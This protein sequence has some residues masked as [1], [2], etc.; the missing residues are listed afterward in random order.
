[1]Q[2]RISRDIRTS[3]NQDGAVVLNVRANR[4]LNLNLAGAAIL[5]ML[6]CGIVSTEVLAK[7]LVD[8]HG[9]DATTA[10]L[11]VND[12]LEELRSHGLI[13]S[14]DEAEPAA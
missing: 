1:M 14:V 7:S 6:N 5:R 3:Y 10:V 12:F 8:G 4:I 13:E 11:D 9:I 2:H